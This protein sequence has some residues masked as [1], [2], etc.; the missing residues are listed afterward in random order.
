MIGGKRGDYQ[1]CSVL[2]Y[3]MKLCT[4]ISTLTVDEQFLQFSALG[5]V[6]LGPFHCAWIHLCSCLCFCV[7][8][9]YCMCVVSLE[10]G[11]VDLVGLK[12]NP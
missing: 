12:P 7:I 11:G 6:S 2:Y 4:V 10:H 9:S 5:F 8:L 1:S 3:V